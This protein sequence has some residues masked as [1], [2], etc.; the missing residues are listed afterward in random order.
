MEQ[1]VQH[2]GKPARKHLF[3]VGL[4][5]VIKVLVPLCITIG[6]VAWLFHKVNMAQLREAV[7][8]NIHYG[9]LVGMMCTVTLSQIIRGIRWGIQLRAVGVPRMTPVAESV[10]I[11]SAYAL[12]Y[13]FPFLGEG[14]RCVYISEYEH[15]RLSTVVGTDLGDRASDGV[16]IGMLIILAIIVA[17]P[18][19]MR[20]ADHYAVGEKIMHYVSDVWFWVS[21]IGF[22]A[23]FLLVDYRFRTRPLVMKFNAGAK[24]IWDGFAVLF[25]MKGIGMYLLLTIGIWVCYF[26]NT[27]LCFFAFD[28]T[29]GLVFDSHDFGLTAGLVVFV[30]GSCSMIVPSNGGLGPWNV[31]VM[32]ALMLYGVG[33]TDATA[34]TLVCWTFQAM[35]QVVLGIFSAIYI[36]RRMR[37]TPPTGMAPSTSPTPA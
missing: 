13:V 10:A 24:R 5:K 11:F 26:L 30:F 4:E 18:A 36:A 6:L 14:W 3:L 29:R 28:F 9:Y 31:A 23:A 32:F 8:R 12:N 25:H 20:F 2:T 15:T 34:Y 35:I 22:T 1:N 21:L 37:K 19:M 33:R 16:V 7:E 27:Y 17:N